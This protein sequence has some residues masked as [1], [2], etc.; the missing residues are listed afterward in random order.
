MFDHLGEEKTSKNQSL[1]ILAKTEHEM[2]KKLRPIMKS[3][4]NLEEKS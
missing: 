1:E 4:R 3:W 2:E